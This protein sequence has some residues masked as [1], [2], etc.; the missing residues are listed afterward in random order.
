MQQ[1]K[2]RSKKG[3]ILLALAL[4]LFVLAIV[5][6]AALAVI[7]GSVTINGGL[8][9]TISTKTV[10]ITYKSISDPAD[11][12][13]AFVFIQDRCNGGAWSPLSLAVFAP[14][15]FLPYPTGT[16]VT[17]QYTL[18]SKAVPQTWDTFQ[19]RVGFYGIAP[20]YIWQEGADWHFAAT[21]ADYLS[22]EVDFN[23]NLPHST[24]EFIPP[25]ALG[26]S[27]VNWTNGNALGQIW[28]Q[29]G[30]DNGAWMGTTHW[31]INDVEQPSLAWVDPFGFPDTPP[32]PQK[33]VGPPVVPYSNDGI[34]TITH[35]AVSA[36]GVTQPGLPSSDAIGYDTKDPTVFWADWLT[37]PEWNL[38]NVPF[39]AILTDS[40]GS[41]IYGPPY[42]PIFPEPIDP[43][44]P[45]EVQVQVSFDDGLTYLPNVGVAGNL[46]NA[47]GNA[48]VVT[49]DTFDLY[50]FYV[51]G[52]VAVLPLTHAKYR[53]L[54]DTWDIAGNETLTYGYPHVDNMAPSTVVQSVDPAGSQLFMN[55]T[56]KPVTVILL[57]TDAGGNGAP[58][59]VKS[60]EYFIGNSG[61][62]SPVL[63][64]IASGPTGTVTSTVNP[65]SVLIDK[66]QPTGPVYLFYRSLDVAGNKEAWKVVW[67]W[68]D[69]TAPVLK[70]DSTGLWYTSHT[71][72]GG[73]TI[74]L[75]AY[76]YNSEIA[77]PGIEYQ[78]PG[79]PFPVTTTPWL[80]GQLPTKW[81]PLPGNP[82]TV[83]IPIDSYPASRTDG[84]WSLNYRATDMAGNASVDTTLT[85]KI[86]TRP[87]TTVGTAGFGPDNWINGSVPFGLTATDQAIGA[88]VR[89]TFYRVDQG[90]PW[91]KNVD[92][93]PATA[94]VTALAPFLPVQGA[95]HTIDFFSIDNAT[96]ETTTTA[97][98]YPG[99]V[100]QGVLVGS[101]AGIP[102]LPLSVTGYKS[103][104]VKLDVTVPVVTAMDPK[105]GAWQKGPGIVNFSG[106]DIGSGYAYT[107]WSTDAGV[108]WTAGESAEIGGNSP[109]AGTV[110]TYRG[111]DHVGLMSANATI[112]VK[113]ASTPP[114]VTGGNVSVKKGNKAAFMFNV[115]AVTPKSPR[116]IIQI[117]TK[118][119]QTLSSH[120]FAN[121]DTNTDVTRSFRI[122]LKKGKYNI[123]IS[124]IDEAGNVQT[125]R[126]G[127]TLTVN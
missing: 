94:F 7:P 9:D 17:Q 125:K 54:I 85:V 101:W 104:T 15:Q 12:G 66:T 48:P 70:S 31:A 11:L 117:R 47:P 29:F 119:G 84:M 58:S 65:T 10:S 111:V 41:G 105:N 108:T 122:N 83:W 43:P 3:V 79:W 28:A 40:G 34:Y 53:I 112:T 75:T 37:A 32:I 35:W 86:D 102:Y 18:V 50:K 51:K 80:I 93:V 42:A 96:T 115:T 14:P 13:I 52:Q 98:P 113:V 97:D 114:T 63:G 90:T 26:R 73:F 1:T 2:R 76:D 124:A 67:I 81:T 39:T 4:A 27:G 21:P 95:M 64:S 123:R 77:P 8:S 62:A 38:Q 116:V 72:L 78:V 33:V 16:T 127:G 22:N 24:V 120:N 106:S 103:S 107:E 6:A 74:K 88:G 82:G 25:G 23:N 110:V 46:Q 36:S 89:V 56:K 91:L 61:S 126:G 71:L 92:A 109:A 44:R 60:T 87:P 19:V 45:I 99:N 121:I 59:G 69:N 55:W 5:P 30:E 49:Q 118:S 68:F 100:E 57:A 20:G